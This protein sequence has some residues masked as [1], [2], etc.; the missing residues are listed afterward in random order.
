PLPRELTT[1]PVTKMCFVMNVVFCQ[2]QYGSTDAGSVGY[3][4]SAPSVSSRGPPALPS[5]ELSII[6]RRV[7]ANRTMLDDGQLNP[8]AGFQGPQLF[9]LLQL[10]QPRGRQLRQS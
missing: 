5:Y 4:G 2:L 1:P 3:G 8:R 6:I 10:L 7:D 9:Q